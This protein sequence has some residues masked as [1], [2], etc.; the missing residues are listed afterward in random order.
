MFPYYWQTNNPKGNNTYST[1][2]WVGFTG[3]VTAADPF[4]FAWEATYGEVKHENASHLNRQGFF[5]NAMLEYKLDW[6]VPGIYGWYASGD[7]DNPKDG[8]ERMPML[9][10]NYGDYPLSNF[11]FSGSL[12]N[13]PYDGAAFNTDPTGTWG[14]GIRLR[15]MSFIEN[16][17]HTLRVHLMGGTNDPAMAK[18]MLGKKTRKGTPG[19]VATDFYDGVASLYLTTLDNVVEVNL[20][21]SYKIYENLEM[22]LELGYMHLWLDQSKSMWGSGRPGDTTQRGVSTTDAMKASLTFMYRF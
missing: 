18:Y 12:S 20:D 4:R 2:W 16:L 13:A 22:I 21:T 5:I 17:K 11:G 15:D 7:N 19:G 6:G 9:A 3:E 14:I 1:A 8:S 10:Q